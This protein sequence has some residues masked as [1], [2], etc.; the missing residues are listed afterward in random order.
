[1]AK[2]IIFAGG[3]SR[4]FQRPGEP[5]VDKCT[6]PVGGRP[7]I[8]AVA[9]AARGL[10]DGIYVAPGRNVLPGYPAVE[11]SPGFSGPLAAVV[12]A[13]SRFDDVLLFAPC[14]VPYITGRV[15]G[16]LLRAPGTAVLVAPNGL[17]ESHIFKAEA[18]ELRRMADALSRR[19][20]RLDDVFRLSRTAMYLSAARHGI[21]RRELHNV[22]FREELEPPAEWGEVVF[23]EDLRLEWDPPLARYLATGS[24]D[25][26]WSELR[27][28]L[29]A[30]LY[31]MAAHVLDDLAEGNRRLA[32]VA[33][34]LK[35]LV[36]IRKSA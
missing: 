9:E 32:P 25:F 2:L 29:E 1:M 8:E 18:G 10:V 26:L 31:S 19:G 21:S 33:K 28:Y 24:A 30:G 12:S 11:D 22:N 7:M 23:D 4:R 3:Q 16:E 13:A 5:R 20:G 6:Y 27:T 15:F 34:A 35:E 14:D 17:V 36:G